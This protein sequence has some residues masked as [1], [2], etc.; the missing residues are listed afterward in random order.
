[1]TDTSPQYSSKPS[2]GSFKFPPSSSFP[3]LPPPSLP[4]SYPDSSKTSKFFGASSNNILPTSTRQPAAPASSALNSGFT[5]S[6]LTGLHKKQ[7]FLSH[8]FTP[9][10]YQQTQSPSQQ[11]QGYASQLLPKSISTQ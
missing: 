5:A 2:T 11:L 1:M 8:P 4:S 6:S 3:P 9:H 10:K 7:P